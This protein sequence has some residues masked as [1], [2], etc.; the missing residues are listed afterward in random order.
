MF[1]LRK[2]VAGPILGA[3]WLWWSYLAILP[4]KATD[5]EPKNASSQNVC[6]DFSLVGK[7]KIAFSVTETRLICGDPQNDA[8]NNIPDSQAMFHLKTFLQDRG[9]YS[10][11]LTRKN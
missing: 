5:P 9:Y 8:W 11:K 6:P 3:T 7:E 10:P 1:N 4:S 2:A